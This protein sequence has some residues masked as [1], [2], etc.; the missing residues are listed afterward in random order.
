M[1]DY[2][3]E[4]RM[5]SLAA[6]ITPSEEALDGLRTLHP[7][8]KAKPTYARKRILAVSA[9]S[10]VLC[11][12]MI[13]A[14]AA[15]AYHISS[16]VYEKVKDAGLTDSEIDRLDS[17]LHSQGF[18]DEHISN[19]SPLEV[20]ENG[21]TYGPDALGADLIAVLMADGDIGYVYRDDLYPPPPKSLEEALA[22]SGKPFTIPVYDKDGKT[23]IGTMTSNEQARKLLPNEE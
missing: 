9:A 20:N 21:Q 17:E 19:F 1:H 18:S 16:A 22:I 7:E 13:P 23:V 3:F 5:K 6:D 11:V 14:I 10:A 15:G 2:E 12:M 4:T 8:A